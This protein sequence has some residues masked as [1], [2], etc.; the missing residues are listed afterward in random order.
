MKYSDL[1]TQ[2]ADQLY[3]WTDNHALP[4]AQTD[5]CCLTPA[6]PPATSP[7]AAA[8]S[9][10]PWFSPRALQTLWQTGLQMRPRPRPWSKVL[11]VGQSLPATAANGL[12]STGLSPRNHRISSQLSTTPSDFGRDLC[13]Q[14]RVVVPS[15]GILR[16]GYEL[17]P[18]R[19]VAALRS[20]TWQSAGRQHALRLARQRSSRKGHGG[21]A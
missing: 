6:P 12:R 2:L 5:F 19:S 3:T 1:Q 16:N 21:R 18:S 7:D 17:C 4:A 9:F 8:R 13:H 20:R 14:S 10:A 15:R 11:P